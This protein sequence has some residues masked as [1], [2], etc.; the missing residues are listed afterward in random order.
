M[1]NNLLTELMPSSVEFEIEK[2]KSDRA[3]T[4]EATFRLKCKTAKDLMQW[5]EDFQA[6]TGAVWNLRSSK[7]N[8]PTF[9]YRADFICD[10]SSHRKK[11]NDL[12]NTNCKA[13]M[14]L[15]VIIYTFFSKF[16]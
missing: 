8:A 6:K 5:K 4:F 2:F 11:T 13:K 12:R 9:C 15:K 10:H 1:D 14:A 16:A 3:K 7:P